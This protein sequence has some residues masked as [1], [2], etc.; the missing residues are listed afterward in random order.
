MS[1]PILKRDPSTGR[2]YTP[3]KRFRVRHLKFYGWTIE[4]LTDDG[5]RFVTRADTLKEARRLIGGKK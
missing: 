4:E 2:Y 3:D 5:Y 1:K